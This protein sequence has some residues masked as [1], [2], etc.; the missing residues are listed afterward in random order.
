MF[1]LDSTKPFIV[2][3]VCYH[4]TTV[5]AVDDEKQFLD[6]L[7]FEVSDHLSLKCFDTP[8]AALE[9]IKNSRELQVPFAARLHFSGKNDSQECGFARMRESAIQDIIHPSPKGLGKSKEQPVNVASKN[10]VQIHKTIGDFNHS[11][12]ILT[13]AGLYYYNHFNEFEWIT[14]DEEKLQQLGLAF[15]QEIDNLSHEQLH[16][17]T[18]ITHHHRPDKLGFSFREVRNEVYNKNRFKEIILVS[19]DYDMPGKNGIEFIK[20]VAFPGVTL[21]HI[22][23]IL[24]GKISDEF[25]QKLNT[26]P[27]P[28]EYI[29]KS[30]SDRIKKLLKLVE[31]KTSRV[32]Q[33]CS[34]KALTA[35]SK[36]TNEEACFTF[37]KQFGAIFTS[38]LQDNHICELYLFD[39]QGSYLL[40][41]DKA[42]L[43][44]FIMRSEKGMKNSMQLAKEHN[45]PE[46][47]IDAL[48]TKRCLLSLYEKED[49]ARLR[50]KEIAWDNYL[51]PASVYELK[52]PGK[53]AKKFYYAFIKEFPAHGMDTSK[54]L[55]YQAFLNQA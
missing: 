37:D 26:L 17:I 48:Q 35:L 52:M 2:M 7:K 13:E 43:S 14:S 23:I 16:K 10:S 51:H 6:A 21:E 12:Y 31:E 30:D 5:L 49:V 25:K 1:V 32:F 45:A 24:T 55:S 33:E 15:P 9:Y 28:T 46:S 39:R 50:G 36:D 54:I 34:Y 40:L 3:P 41:D 18:D 29:G 4:P 20:A 38:Y 42:N 44:W 19:T 8:E 47:V 22:I 11:Y 53:D 27:L